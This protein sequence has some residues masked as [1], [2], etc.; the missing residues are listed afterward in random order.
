MTTLAVNVTAVTTVA[1]VETVVTHD[2]LKKLDWIGRDL[3]GVS[4][5][6]VRMFHEDARKAG[7][8]C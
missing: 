6:T 3:S 1:Q 2:I 8:S 5:E 4:L 7:L